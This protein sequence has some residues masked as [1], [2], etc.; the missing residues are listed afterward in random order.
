MTTYNMNYEQYKIHISKICNRII[1]EKLIYIV[2]DGIH[3]VPSE[4]FMELDDDLKFNVEYNL[5]V[6]YQPL[7]LSALAEYKN[8]SNED[9]I[10]QTH[11]NKRQK[12]E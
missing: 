7:I 11:N 8:Q 4:W 6:F 12:L 1:K 9:L 3:V 10:Y 2:N 5:K